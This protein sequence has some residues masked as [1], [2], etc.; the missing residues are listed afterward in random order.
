MPAGPRCW[1]CCLSIYSRQPSAFSRQEE[2]DSGKVFEIE[3][4]NVSAENKY[5]QSAS[6]NGQPFDQGWIRHSDIV[7]G[8]NLV[9]EMGEKPNKE[10]ARNN[11]PP[12]L[13]TL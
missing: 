3:A 10:W 7:K 8:G 12:S 6:L 11:L 5:I 9:F 13:S 2:L 4:R 1:R